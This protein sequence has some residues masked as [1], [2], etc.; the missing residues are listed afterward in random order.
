MKINKDFSKVMR[1][2][3]AVMRSGR[4]AGKITYMNLNKHVY[5]RE[6]ES[7]HIVFWCMVSAGMIIILS[8]IF[9]N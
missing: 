1:H 6:H 7:A 3:R 9:I 5:R 8:V 4:M 2:G